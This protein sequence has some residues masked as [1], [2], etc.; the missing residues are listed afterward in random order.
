M[1]K[2]KVICNEYCLHR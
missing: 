1:Q 2:K